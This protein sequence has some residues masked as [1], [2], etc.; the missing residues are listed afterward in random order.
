MAPVRTL[1]AAA[2]RHVAS[3]QWRKYTLGLQAQT[4]AQRG[5]IAR[6]GRVVR[7]TRTSRV[8]GGQHGA[9]HATCCRRPHSSLAATG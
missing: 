1:M 2:R 3:R 5:Q 4:M 7:V 6:S 9:C 8:L